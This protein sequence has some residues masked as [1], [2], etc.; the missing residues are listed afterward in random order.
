MSLIEAI[1]AKIKSTI[2][3]VES[4]GKADFEAVVKRVEAL[5][6]EIES[7][8]KATVAKL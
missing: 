4:V 3:E 7:V 8:V 1:E 5:E 6:A 2:A